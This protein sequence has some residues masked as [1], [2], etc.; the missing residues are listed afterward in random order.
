MFTYTYRTEVSDSL[1]RELLLLHPPA[2]A[3]GF[4]PD[5]VGP[6]AGGTTLST[7]RLLLNNGERL[8]HISRGSLLSLNTLLLKIL[9]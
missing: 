7:K 3:A 6:L 5:L 4:G 8:F 9:F 1:Q 2:N